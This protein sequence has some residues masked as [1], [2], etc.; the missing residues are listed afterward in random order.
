VHFMRQLTVYA[1]GFWMVCGG[2]ALGQQAAPAERCAGLT[3][4]MLEGAKVTSAVLVPAG[5]ALAVKLEAR[6]VG[7]LPAF[8]RVSVTDT[9]TG[10][11][12]IKTEVWLP[13]AGWNGRY[14]AEGNGG[15]AGEI[16]FS[17]LAGAVA[18]GY[19]TSGTDTGHVEDG[20]KFALGHPEKVKDFGWRAVH[21]MT[22]QTKVLV[23]AF[24]GKAAGHSYFTACSDGGREALME[25]QRFPGDF[26]GILAG[27]PAYNWTALIS[28]A[29]AND[30]TLMATPGAYLPA[31][32][33]PAITA[34][35]LAACDGQ[36]G[37][38]DGVV[39]NPAACRFDPAVLAC[40]EAETDGC[41]TAGQMAT[42]K[43]IYAAKVDAA[44]RQMF[45]GYSPGAESAPGSWNG[46]MVGK[47]QGDPAAMM[48][49][50]LGYFKDFVFEREDWSLGTFDFDRDSKL[51]LEKTGA[52]LNATDTNLKP[53]AARGGKLLMY[54]GWNDP[55]IP[56]L[57]SVEYYDGM[58]ASMGKKA[59][60]AAVRLY[61]VPG[62]LHCEGGPGVT[63]FGQD[64]A[65]VRGDAQQDVF[66][67]L[68]KWVE[69]GKA[70]GTLTARKFVDGDDTKGVVGTRPVC[71]YPTWAKYVK[72]DAKDAGSF[73]CV[74]E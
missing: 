62:M 47:K 43:S 71:A 44:G 15:F 42:L 53:F 5:A 28:A 22:V 50:G 18:E 13:V 16:Y 69:V 64:G 74:A 60:E 31:S 11:S 12:D 59:T 51:A 19:A 20:A 48:Y 21:D 56:A 72:G 40:K 10:D 39:G 36:D 2:C 55:A 68:E 30:Q 65:A 23:K 14:R 35:V 63:D 24:Y 26:D 6:Q 57:S 9:P 27:A 46:W 7:K 3:G 58:V 29:T 32:K 41:L 67:A 73:S 37:L 52:A 4:V 54:H 25:A 38:K 17:A 45:P 66:T 70:P 8:C 1:V 49:F 34:A 33:L 61:M